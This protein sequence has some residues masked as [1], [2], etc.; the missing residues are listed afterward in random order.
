MVYLIFATHALLDAVTVYGTRLLWPVVDHPFGIGSMFIIDPLYTLPLM[1]VTVWALFQS[2]LD[3]RFA[4]HQRCAD[5]HD[6]L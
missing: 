2:G 3:D 6:S 5:I 1:I 4:G